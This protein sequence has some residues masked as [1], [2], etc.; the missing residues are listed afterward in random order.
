MTATG[1]GTSASGHTHAE[2]E[3]TGL[4]TDLAGKAATTHNH[5]GTYAATSHTH[6]E[7]DVTN[8]AT[9]LAGK[10]D[11]GHGHAQA[12]VTGLATA[13]AGKS[14]TSHGHTGTYAPNA[15]SHAEADVTGLIID[16][17]GKADTSHNHTGTYANATHAHAESDVTNLA[18]DLAGKA[19]SSHNHDGTYATAGHN[20]TGTYATAGHTHDGAWT[21]MLSLGTNIQAWATQAPQC[22]LTDDSTM[23]ELSGS[24]E[25]PTSNITVAGGATIATLP[26]TH[27]PPYDMKIAVRSAGA[28]ATGNTL[29][30]DTAGVIT[31]GA[32]LT[33]GTG[34]NTARLPVDSV[35]FRKV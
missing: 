23:V 6:A 2:S 27:R 17:V 11:T 16:L 5:A 22:R 35:R 34:T 8:L 10:S 4:T 12:D 21:A 9:D 14:D 32:S 31:F 13:L 28:G 19:S 33:S 20:H 26:T 15:H 1:Y 29:T 18:T 24:F 3:V 30:I 7:T 25:V